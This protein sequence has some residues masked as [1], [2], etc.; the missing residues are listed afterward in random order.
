[1]LQKIENA[2]KGV[3]FGTDNHPDGNFIVSG[4]E[5][6]LVKIWQLKEEQGSTEDVVPGTTANQSISTP[7]ENAQNSEAQN[8]PEL[9]DID[10][11]VVFKT[12]DN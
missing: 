1:M 6:H 4:G 9:M 2:H 10:D 7:L 11:N 5:D 3:I 12:E 8:S